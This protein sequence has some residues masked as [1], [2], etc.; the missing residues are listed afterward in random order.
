MS[1]GKQIL[2]II[3]KDIIAELRTKEMVISMLI[4]V[5]LAMIIFSQAFNAA[6]KSLVEFGGGLLWVAFLFTSMLGLNRSFV[7]EKDEGCL[8]GLL[9]SPVDRPL[10][11]FGKMLGNLIFLMVVEVIAIPIFLVLFGLNIG[12]SLIGPFVAAILLGNIG[13]SSVGTLL[14]TISINTKTRDLMLPILFL[15]I[16]I[17]LLIAAVG[18]TGGIISGDREQLVSAYAAMRFMAV[19][20]IIFLL[21]AYALYDFVI[22]E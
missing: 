1:G 20:D 9:M 18:A 22:G 5:I 3:K 14:S 21:V 7:H 4:F 12:A 13:I 8:E 10:I 15:P 17:P 2:A 16:I 19:Y 11:F 6:E